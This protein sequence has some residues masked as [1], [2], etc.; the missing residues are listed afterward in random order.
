MAITFIR[1]Y[2]NYSV[3]KISNIMINPYV[4]HAHAHAH[5]RMPIHTYE[6]P[7]MNK[8]LRVAWYTFENQTYTNWPKKII[9]VTKE[10]QTGT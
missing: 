6:L 5:A 9:R 4:L 7:F 8:S 2:Y 3:S 1:N 10:D